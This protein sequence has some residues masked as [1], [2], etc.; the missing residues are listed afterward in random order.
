MIVFDITLAA[1]RLCD[2]LETP[3]KKHLNV[4]EKMGKFFEKSRKS[5]GSQN[6]RW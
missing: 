3:D 4:S 5:F 6:K 1:E 2:F